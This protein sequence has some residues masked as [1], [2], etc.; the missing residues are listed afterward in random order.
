MR[1][2]VAIQTSAVTR[3]ATPSISRTFAPL[4]NGRTAGQEERRVLLVQSGRVHVVHGRR[5]GP[6]GRI[7]ATGR[8]R[9]VVLPRVVGGPG[10]EGRVGVGIGGCSRCV[11]VELVAGGQGGMTRSQRAEGRGR[12]RGR[13]RRMI[14]VV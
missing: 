9:H 6:M 11:G 5:P 7:R 12:G 1:R 3:A 13:V 2:A 8:G 14:L 4:S 10:E